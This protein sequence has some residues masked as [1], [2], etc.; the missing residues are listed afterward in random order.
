MRKLV[1]EVRAFLAAL[2]I[3]GPDFPNRWEVERSEVKLV[4][5]VRLR[6]RVRDMAPDA[7]VD[8]VDAVVGACLYLYGPRYRLGYKD[9]LA[10]SHEIANDLGIDPGRLTK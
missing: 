8:A 7:K 2:F 5:T 9:W 4:A 1:T 6:A 10:L 3:P